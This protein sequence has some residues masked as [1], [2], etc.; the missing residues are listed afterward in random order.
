MLKFR[1]KMDPR[2]T[3]NGY[4]NFDY[5]FEFGDLENLH[6]RRFLQI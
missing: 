6:N 4:L 2:E 5:R 3:K 1:K